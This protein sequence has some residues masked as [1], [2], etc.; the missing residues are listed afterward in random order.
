MVM[1]D[2]DGTTGTDPEALAAELARVTEGGVDPR[3]PAI[4]GGVAVRSA[5]AAG[6]GAL[7][8]GRWLADVVLA[9]GSKV[10]LRDLATLE[11]QHDG[12]RGEALAQALI[13]SAGR[14][15]AAVGAVA[16]A[17]VGAE[18]LA[19]PAWLLVPAE[20]LVE[21]LLIAAIEMKLIAELGEVHG[22]PVTGTPTA[23]GYALAR[24][25][26]ER[27][28]VHPA[29]L[30]ERGGLGGLMGQGA[31]REL[32]RLVRRRLLTRMGRNLTSLAP[33]LAG[34]V[35]GAEVNRR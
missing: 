27:R 31:R 9:L 3:S 30:L 19:P 22:E 16:G 33:L 24:A 17:L 35:A 34:A 1:A 15:S 18:E 7:T 23:R 6:A 12:L 28:G 2:E 26:A 8:T 20:L 11:A 21:T 25:W 32:A 10:P 14:S 13:R 4:A 29:M 5:R